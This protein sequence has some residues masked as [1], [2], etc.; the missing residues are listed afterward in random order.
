MSSLDKQE[1]NI[2]MDSPTT[3]V[4]FQCI[5][6]IP[7]IQRADLFINLCLIISSYVLFDIIAQISKVLGC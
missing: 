3:V 6:W 2:L 5:D 7:G 4:K 1:T